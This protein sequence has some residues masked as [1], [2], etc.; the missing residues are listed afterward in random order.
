MSDELYSIASITP[1][2][3][4]GS[5]NPDGSPWS[6]PL[7]FAFDDQYVYWLS[8]ADTQHSQN[9]TQDPRVSIVMWSSTEVPRVQGVYI[10]SRAEQITDEAEVQGALGVY[11]RRFD[12]KIPEKFQGSPI[13]R[14]P[15]G[16]INTTKSRGGRRYFES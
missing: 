16:D 14:A 6:T 5:I 9:I 4:L 11:A 1:V 2:G 13:Y 15:L 12:G 3:S 10:Q 7:H 8:S